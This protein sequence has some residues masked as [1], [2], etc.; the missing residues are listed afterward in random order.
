M[1][2]RVGFEPTEAFTSPHFECGAL[3]RAMR[4][5]RGRLWHL[6]SENRGA[7]ESRNRSAAQP[8]FLD[9]FL[10]AEVEGQ[11]DVEPVRLEGP[12]RHVRVGI[13]DPADL[14]AADERDVLEELILVAGG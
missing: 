7:E 10:A 12:R 9:S 14:V 1:A 2:E 11:L 4:P 6:G 3:D 5:L 13:E 8:R